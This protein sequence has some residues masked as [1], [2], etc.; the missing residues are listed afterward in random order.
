M[1][2]DSGARGFAGVSSTELVRGAARRE[3][4]LITGNNVLVRSAPV[5]RAASGMLGVRINY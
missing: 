3:R 1:L 5:H 4:E 2:S